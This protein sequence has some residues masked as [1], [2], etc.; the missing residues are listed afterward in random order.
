MAE[1]SVGSTFKVE[2][3]V[4]DAR[5]LFSVPFQ[6][7]FDP[8]VLSLVNVDSGEF[9]GAMARPRPWSIGMKAEV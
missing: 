7:Q 6:L 9:L 4:S 8:K 3:T 1:Q 2:V 5:D